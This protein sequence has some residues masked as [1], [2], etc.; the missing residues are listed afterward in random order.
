MHRISLWILRIIFINLYIFIGLV[1]LIENKIYCS[2]LRKLYLQ[3]EILSQN[4]NTY[5]TFRVH[6][7]KYV[8][9][10]QRLYKKIEKKITVIWM[11]LQVFFKE[12][13][14]KYNYQSNIYVRFICITSIFKMILSV[15]IQIFI[16]WISLKNIYRIKNFR[17]RF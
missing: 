15:V 11:A 14:S 12:I 4:L 2:F 3:G 9:L 6:P 5:S 17:F 10:V 8:V 1:I 16:E 7:Q 13:R